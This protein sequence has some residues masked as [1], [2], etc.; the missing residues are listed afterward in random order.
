MLS[1]SFTQQERQLNELKDKQL[2]PQ[3][4]FATMT[5]DN[6][7][8]PVHCLVKHETVHPS[9]KDEYHTILADF[10]NDHFSFRNNDKR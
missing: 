5:H 7:I 1:S 9:Q 6:Q 2:P 3:I 8:K 10:V 4:H